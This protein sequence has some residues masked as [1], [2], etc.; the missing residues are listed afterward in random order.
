MNR[1]I[2][3]WE[4]KTAKTKDTQNYVKEEI[5]RIFIG[6]IIIYLSNCIWRIYELYLYL[7]ALYNCRYQNNF[8]IEVERL[9]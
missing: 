4:G 3:P 5:L 7:V 8:F 2:E 9:F 1:S 6:E